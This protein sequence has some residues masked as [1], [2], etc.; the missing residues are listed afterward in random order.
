MLVMK[1]LSYS[2]LYGA[3]RAALERLKRSKPKLGLT[4]VQRFWKRVTK[5]DSCWFWTLRGGE[6]RP[7]EYGRFWDGRK[8]VAANRFSLELH[9]SRPLEANREA[10][11]T[12]D[13][14]ACVNPFH[15]FEGT[16]QQN[17]QDAERKGRLRITEVRARPEVNAKLLA[18]AGPVAGRVRQIRLARGT[19]QGWKH[20]DETRARMSAAARIR[21]EKQ[22]SA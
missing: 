18:Q 3:E 20:T 12:C 17:I 13:V 8:I 4:T 21:W 15:L 22:K 5:T 14:P 11:H 1:S 6:I 16:H 10:C 19:D 2:S 9:L 7:G